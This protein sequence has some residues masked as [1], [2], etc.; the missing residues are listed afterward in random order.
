MPNQSSSDIADLRREYTQGGLRRKDL[1]EDP[2]ALFELWLKQACN[3]QIPDPTAMSVATVDEQ[4]RPYQR[5]V[6][7]KHYH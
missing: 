4:G 3:A 7:L 1:P 6:L 5:I 2:L